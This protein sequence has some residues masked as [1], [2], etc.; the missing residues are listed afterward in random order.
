MPGYKLMESAE[1][2]NKFEP[3]LK[4]TRDYAIEGTKLDGSQLLQKSLTTNSVIKGYLDK[5]MEERGNKETKRHEAEKFRYY[6]V[7]SG[8][9]KRAK[10]AGEEFM[11]PVTPTTLGFR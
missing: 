11:R 5:V 4:L 3:A 2:L 6:W 1:G 9:L 7:F 8:Q 10:K